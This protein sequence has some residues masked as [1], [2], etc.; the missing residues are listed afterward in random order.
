MNYDI[1]NIAISLIP[2]VLILVMALYYERYPPK[3]DNMSYGFRRGITGFSMKN[4][5][6]WME[7][8]VYSSKLLIYPAIFNVLFCLYI[9]IYLQNALAKAT[10]FSLCLFAVSVLI[11]TILCEFHLRKAFDKNGNK[12]EDSFHS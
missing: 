1:L 3:Y 7:A 8:N 6:T 5:N 11:I 12:K 4:D 9:G 2:A 10:V